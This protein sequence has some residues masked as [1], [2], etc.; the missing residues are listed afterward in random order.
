MIVVLDQPGQGV[1]SV[2]PD[3]TV[4]AIDL[5]NG[6]DLNDNWRTYQTTIDRI[7]LATGYDLLSQVPVEVQAVLEASLSNP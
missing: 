1:G 7:E 6:N 2:S 3:S 5:P 4:I